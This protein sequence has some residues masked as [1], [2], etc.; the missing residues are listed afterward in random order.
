[1][2]QAEET[3]SSVLLGGRGSQNSGYFQVG[4]GSGYGSTVFCKPGC[5]RTSLNQPASN[6]HLFGLNRKEKELFQH[7]ARPNF[8]RILRMRAG[9]GGS[10]SATESTSGVWGPHPPGTA[11]KSPCSRH[12]GSTREPGGSPLSRACAM[13]PAGRGL[14]A[15]RWGHGDPRRPRLGQNRGGK[16]GSG[17]Q[18]G[19]GQATGEDG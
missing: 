13:G 4:C 2:R 3:D 9:Y 16:A 7:E 8:T 18:A 12:P 19:A 15:A 14:G 5:S 10:D 17:Q 1:M 6:K 11:E